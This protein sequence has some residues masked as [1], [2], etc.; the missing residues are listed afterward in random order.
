MINKSRYDSIDSYLSNDE[1][2]KSKYDD[3]DLV[4]DKSI[5]DK[6]VKEGVDDKLAKHIA[7]LFIRDPLVI[8]EELLNVDDTI[9]SD[10]FEV[11]RTKRKNNTHDFN[12]TFNLPTGKPYVSNLLHLIPPLAGE[13]NS[14]VW[15]FNSPILKMLLIPS[16]LSSCVVPF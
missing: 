14:E 7:H 15:T 1:D 3:M 11:K 6:L 10:H 13:W 8:F 2:Y 16:L 12:R 5:H 9:S 4:Y